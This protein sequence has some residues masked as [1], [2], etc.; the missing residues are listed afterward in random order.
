[1]WLAIYAK[2]SWLGVM[3]SSEIASYEP[4]MSSC[5]WNVAQRYNWLRAQNWLTGCSKSSEPIL[6]SSGLIFLGRKG[7]STMGQVDFH[8]KISTR[9]QSQK[10]T[11]IPRLL[12]LGENLFDIAFVK[13]SV[14][15]IYQ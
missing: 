14:L 4:K 9:I 5:M 2:N 13:L 7:V 3:R 10:R 12:S 1:M 11:F 6:R 8:F 15:K